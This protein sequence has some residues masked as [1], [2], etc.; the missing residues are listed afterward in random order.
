VSEAEVRA[1]F[2]PPDFAVVGADEFNAYS[3]AHMRG[4]G[5]GGAYFYKVGRFAVVTNQLVSGAFAI[6]FD[7]A[8]KV[9]Y[10]LGF[11]VND[12]DSLAD[13]GTDT[14]SERRIAP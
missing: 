4:L 14:R 11:G 10:R 8:G 3:I 2:G 9:V 5:A 7:P 1:I 12:G 6:V 13:I